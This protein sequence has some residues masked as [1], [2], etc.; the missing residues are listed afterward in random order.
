MSYKD[1]EYQRKYY[2]KNKE[3][4]KQYRI[5]NKDKKTEY[6]KEYREKN[7]D[8]IKEY[9]EKNKEKI[10]EKKKEYNKTPAGIKSSR[11]NNWKYSGIIHDNY[12]ELYERYLNTEFCEECNVKLTEDKKTTKTTR[13][14]DH[15]HNTGFVRNIVCNSCNVKRQ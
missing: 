2:E 7:K 15:D 13:C 1:P 8:K 9:R 14:L 4:K 10:A 3:R 11:I 6:M 5:K 12:D